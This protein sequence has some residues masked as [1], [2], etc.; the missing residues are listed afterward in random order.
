MHIEFII[1]YYFV[2]FTYFINSLFLVGKSIAEPRI[3]FVPFRVFSGH[4]TGGLRTWPTPKMWANK[5]TSN[6]IRKFIDRPM[7][8]RNLRILYWMIIKPQYRVLISLKS[9]I[10]LWLLIFI[11]YIDSELHLDVIVVL[12]NRPLCIGERTSVLLRTNG[13]E[14]CMRSSAAT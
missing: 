5:N 13:N 12:L 10:A 8:K 11:S 7:R 1:I 6:L 4:I 3:I 9:S 14:T 2:Y